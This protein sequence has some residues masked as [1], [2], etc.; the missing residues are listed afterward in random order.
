MIYPVSDMATASFPS[1]VDDD[2]S[3]NDESFEFRE[4]LS[5]CQQL[6]FNYRLLSN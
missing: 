5:L 1:L 2:H 6:L 4:K 3:L